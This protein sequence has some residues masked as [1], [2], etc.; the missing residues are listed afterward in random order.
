[1]TSSDIVARH[2]RLRIA[3]SACFDVD[4]NDEHEQLWETCG[5]GKLLYDPNSD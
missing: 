1:M 3:L 4:H 2:N 5:D